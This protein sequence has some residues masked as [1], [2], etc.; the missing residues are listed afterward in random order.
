MLLDSS[1][2][3]L[4]GPLP[5]GSL[6]PDGPSPLPNALVARLLEA[7]VLNHRNPHGPFQVYRL[8]LLN[9]TNL[10]KYRHFL[11]KM[12]AE[13]QS[14]HFFALLRNVVSQLRNQ[15]LGLDRG[16]SVFS[17]RVFFQGTLTTYELRKAFSHAKAAG[18]RSP[19]FSPSLG[20][21]SFFLGALGSHGSQ[22]ENH[23]TGAI[24]WPG[25]C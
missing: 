20:S 2:L 16:S 25:N 9:P 14:L 11:F 3:W 13:S 4:P 12:T 18:R 17:S 6:F 15:E 10:S 7:E 21:Q 8:F 19:K 5:I 24:P 1:V 22:L 23:G